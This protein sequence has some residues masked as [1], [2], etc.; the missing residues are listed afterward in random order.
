MAV[1]TTTTDGI[2]YYE[3]NPKPQVT[4]AGKDWD[5]VV[6]VNLT[7]FTVG[8]VVDVDEATAALENW[9]NTVVN[10]VIAAS[11]FYPLPV[12]EDFYGKELEEAYSWCMFESS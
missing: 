9:E 2:D 6:R 3:S 11:Y 4:V 10:E 12:E 1:I 5:I 7:N 8:G